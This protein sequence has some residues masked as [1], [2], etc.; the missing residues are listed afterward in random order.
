MAIDQES[1]K[2]QYFIYL[3]PTLF[4]CATQKVKRNLLEIFKNL[5]KSILNMW[6]FNII[7]INSND[8]FI[9]IIKL[10][11]TLNFDM[12]KHDLWLFYTFL[13]KI[14]KCIFDHVFHPLTHF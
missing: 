6:F 7:D 8:M 13:T 4:F 14:M 3:K 1:K 10:N 5:L 12:L 2:F 11:N 9:L